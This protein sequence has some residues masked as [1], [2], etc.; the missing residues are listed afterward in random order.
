MY[1]SAGDLYAQAVFGRDS[2]EVAEDLLAACPGIAREVIVTLAGLQ[3]AVDAPPGPSSNEEERGRIHHEHRELVIDGHPIS[4]RSQEVLEQLS[5]LWGGTR[6]SMTYYGSVDATPLY[7]RLAAAYCDRHGRSILDHSLV[8]RDGQET[9]VRGCVLLAVAWLER[10]IAES[11][12]GLVEFQRRNPRGISFQVWKDSGTSYVHRDGELANWDAPIAAVEVQGYAYD[13]LHGAARLLGGE[14]PERAAG[15]RREADELRARVLERFWM[16]DE[17]YFAMGID[18]DA[19]GAP[20]Q[21]RSVASNGALLMDTALFDGLPDAERYLRGTVARICG[22]EFLTDAGV[23]CRS[24]AED[25]LIDFQDYHGTWAAWPKEGY[26]VAKGLLRQGFPRLAEQ[27]HAR[28]L[29][30][31]N[32]AGEHAEF[33]YVSPDGHVHYDFRGR[34]GHGPHPTAILGTN[35]PD[36]AQAWT[37]SA[38]LAIKTGPG[39]AGG[40]PANGWRRDLEDEVLGAVPHARRLG[41]R[42]ELEAAY[43]HRGDFVIDLEGGL[44]RARAARRP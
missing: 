30:G 23:R 42:A 43:T 25:G 35:V 40:P 26:D 10:K 38:A 9:T 14:L 13:A 24:L 12:L 21:V 2:V 37:V 18:R 36:Q 16:P 7:V 33:L 8:A 29:N 15:W 28:L 20:R 11:P 22:P 5:A 44:A 39:S 6:T 32:L 17:A 34:S 1:A 27:V 41:D 4:P 3:G 31:V 19:R